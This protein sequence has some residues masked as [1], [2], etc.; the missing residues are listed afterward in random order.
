MCYRKT[1]LRENSCFHIGASRV[2][3]GKNLW[4]LLVKSLAD[5]GNHAP[6]NF[7]IMNFP[8]KFQEK[9]AISNVFE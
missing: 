7:D 3:S 5:H 8:R 4:K 9:W 2:N 1:Y 6:K